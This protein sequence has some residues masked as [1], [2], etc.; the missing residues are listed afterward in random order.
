LTLDRI[1][2]VQALFNKLHENIDKQELQKL[3]RRIFDNLGVDILSLDKSILKDKDK[4]DAVL[5]EEQA[6]QSGKLDKAYE[7]WINAILSAPATH[8]VNTVGNTANAV[9]EYT[10]KRIGEA[11]L[12]LVFRR[13]DAAT[14]GEFKEI[15]K[16]LD[17]KG[18][19]ERSKVAFN[20]EMLSPDNKFREHSSLAIGGKLGRIIRIPTRALSFMDELARN[21]IIPM[22]V[23][24]QAY[25]SGTAKGLK[26]RD[27]QSYI[28]EKLR[29]PKSAEFKIAVDKANELTFKQ[30]PDKF[31]Q[32]LIAL[33]ND[34]GIT[35]T[36]MKYF[37]PFVTAPYNILKQGL[38]KS[39][40]G[41]VN[42]LYQ[43][44]KI[45]A[46]KGKLD[47]RYIGNVAEQFIA[48]GTLLMLAGMDDEDD[49]LPFITGSNAPYGSAEQRY[50]EQNIP[51]YSIRIGGTYVSYKRIEPLATM[52]AITADTLQAYRDVKAGRDFK[53]NF[54]NMWKSV[55]EKS[56][57]NSIDEL[58]R[59][60]EDPEKSFT[61]LGTNFVASWMPNAAKAAVMSAD[62]EV[63]NNKSYEKGLDMWLDQMHVITSKAGITRR[64]PK[65]DPF[66]ETITKENA[67]DAPEAFLYIGRLAG[68]YVKNIDEDDKVKKLILTYNLKVNPD[69]PYWP[70][71]PKNTFTYKGEKCY[72]GNQDYHDFC[73]ES[74]KLAK[75]QLD[76]AVR[77]R[78]LNI[79]NPTEKD[80]KLIKQVFTRARKEVKE[81]FI[82]NGR[83]NQE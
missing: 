37:L 24:S 23:A 17:I 28:Q 29:S 65:I 10:A 14:F 78:L 49:G 64:L 79:N 70:D 77:R 12:N 18:A 31:V 6:A 27:L 69:E 32:K 13:K 15:W 60:F 58:M 55:T 21:I 41:L 33:R 71:I 4:L 26:G 16:N 2:R 72:F 47:S 68:Q 67:E 59:W 11:L 36:L 19:I 42:T 54:T 53:K 61:S 73:V 62:D 5:R 40:L 38:R 48:W 7:Y 50:K 63:R 83:Y 22:E 35:G 9:Y 52:L 81:N 25:R 80:I 56:Y 74:G 57:L 45:A 75:K 3:R 51:P 82:R 44:G 76:N 66:G 39:P 30:E 20:R 34:G 46:G 43:T 8:I 1:E